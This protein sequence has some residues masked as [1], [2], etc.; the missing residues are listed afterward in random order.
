M[1]IGRRPR[2][3]IGRQQ[4]LPRPIC[5]DRRH[6]ERLLQVQPS[7]RFSCFPA[8]RASCNDS[9][10]G[11]GSDSGRLARATALISMIV[12]CVSM[13]MGVEEACLAIG[14][15]VVDQWRIRTQR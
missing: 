15:I 10:G 4:L 8:R 13:P 1:Q 5:R 2:A 6:E 12:L 3:A 11:C 14:T 9:R 7:T